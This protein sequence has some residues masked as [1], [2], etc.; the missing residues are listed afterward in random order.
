M[1]QTPKSR[2]PLKASLVSKMRKSH[3]FGATADLGLSFSKSRRKKKGLNL[4]DDYCLRLPDAGVPASRTVSD[5]AVSMDSLD[6]DLTI[7]SSA[8][9]RLLS[10]VLLPQFTFNPLAHH[11]RNLPWLI[12]R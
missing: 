11:M 9:V 1:S 8:K 6:F 12:G 7:N 2:R 3:S 4:K 10:S 5:D